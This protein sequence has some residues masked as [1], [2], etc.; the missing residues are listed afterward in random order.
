MH[1]T[2]HTAHSFNIKDLAI[3]LGFCSNKGRTI[4]IKSSMADEVK[5]SMESILGNG[6]QGKIIYIIAEWP[7]Q[8]E[9][10]AD[11]GYISKHG[12]VY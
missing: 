6:V 2:P 8:G 12:K 11:K 9:K 5:D 7:A 10:I 1:F 4:I 3:I